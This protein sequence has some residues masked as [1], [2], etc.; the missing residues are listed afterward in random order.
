MKSTI[1]RSRRQS[2]QSGQDRQ[3]RAATAIEGIII[4]AIF[5]V[6]VHTFLEE[7]AI[8]ARWSVETRRYLLLA[9]FFFDLFFTLEFLIRFFSALSVGEASGYFFRR[10]GWIDFLAAVPLL[11]L[12][13]GPQFYALFFAGTMVSGMGRG[14][15]VLKAVKAVRLA[16]ILRL[17]RILK[18]FRNIKYVDSTMAQRHLTRLATLSITVL[19]FGSLMYTT[20]SG[21]LQLPDPI[22]E[23]ERL[24]EVAV[25]TGMDRASGTEE[26]ISQLSRAREELLLIREGEN[27][28][29]SRYDNE[30]FSTRF[31]FEDY[32]VVEYKG[33]SF[34]FDLRS[35]RAVQ[36]RERLSLFLLVLLLLAAILVL[37]GPHFAVSVTD[38]IH[39]MIRGFSE[40]DYSLEV[41]LDPRYKTDD[42]FVLAELY[43]RNWLPLKVRERHSSGRESSTLSMAD[44][45][46]FGFD[47]EQS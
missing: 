44:L 45:S 13:S 18:L 39:V 31:R 21:F 12:D 24:N 34:F 5:L 1:N 23:A 37:Y 28:R 26:A 11:L 47:D 32:Q 25:K 29:F 2:G 7:V 19:V 38:P 3:S 14:L 22:S 41:R 20:V 15:N 9:G 46:D 30:Y 42:I 35:P 6:L 40:D 33:F 4:I 8:L 17:L 16:R 36:A 10:R 43:N 27:A